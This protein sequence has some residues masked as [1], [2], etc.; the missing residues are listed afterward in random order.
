MSILA[1]GDELLR[2]DQIDSNSAF[3]ARRL[4]T[5]GFVPDT[6]SQAADKAGAAESAVAR[7]R[8][9]GGVLIVGG[10]LGPTEDDA[11]R[12]EIARGL[13]EVLVENG[14]ALNWI[15]ERSRRSGRQYTQHTYRQALMPKS[16]E[17]IWNPQGTA[18][19]MLIPSDDDKGG[20]LLVLPGVPRE[21]R[22]ICEALFPVTGVTPRYEQWRLAGTGEDTLAAQLEGFP[23]REGLGFYPSIKGYRLRVPTVDSTDIPQLDR[24]A[25]A[26][27]LSEWLVSTDD[28][29]LE[30]CVLSLLRERGETLAVAESC[31][32]G[33]LGARIGEVPGASDVFLGGFLTYADRVKTQLLGVPAA[34]IEE[35]G[36][37]SSETAC[38]MASGA[39]DSLNADWALAITGIAGPGGARPGKPV[40]T[41]HIALA[42]PGEE[43]PTTQ[44]LQSAWD[45]DTNRNYAV[46]QALTLLWKNV[47]GSS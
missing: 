38:A 41:I 32:A 8:D 11:T 28:E 9:R 2:G 46:L 6:I 47:R 26:E 44:H 16:A 30:S 34:L 23:G 39:R 33:L 17:A 35:H 20:F 12:E 42:G 14:Q 19:G 45:R 37:V 5:L 40:G 27:L 10:G 24:K 1:I 3:A 7:W 29:R 15:R 22:A 21:Y 36:A 4:S 18:P 31:T 13:G 43:A 25:L